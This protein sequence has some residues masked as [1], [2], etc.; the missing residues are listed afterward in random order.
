MILRLSKCIALMLCISPVALIMAQTS[1]PA[2]TD[3]S[4]TSPPTYEPTI[5]TAIT[6]A[7]TTISTIAPTSSAP[8]SVAPITAAPVSLAPTAVNVPITLAPVSAAPTTSAPV[9]LTLAPVSASPTLSPIKAATNSPTTITVTTDAPTKP[10]ATNSPTTIT[11]TT[12]APTTISPVTLAP[13]VATGT[14]TNLS[15][16]ATAAPT[17]SSTTIAPTKSPT[18]PTNAPTLDRIDTSAPTGSPSATPT[19]KAITAA[20]TASPSLTPLI[21]AVSA[22]PTT[23][24]S[25]QTTTQSPSKS[26]TQ[27]PTSSIKPAT[28]SGLKMTLTG[29]GNINDTKSWADN[30]ASFFATQYENSNEMSDIKVDVTYTSEK[31]TSTKKRTMMMRGRRLQTDSVE[32]TYEQLTTYS[33]SNPELTLD[34]VLQMPLMDSTQQAEYVE[35]LKKLNGYASLTTVSTISM[36]SDG[37]N[38]DIVDPGKP[39]TPEKSFPLWAIITIAIVGAALLICIVPFVYRKC[40]R[41]NRSSEQ[42]GLAPPGSSRH[43]NVGEETVGTTDYDYSKAYAASSNFSLS[44][45][46]GTLGERTRQTGDFMPQAGNNTIFSEDPTYNEAA[47]ERS[48]G[49]E[50]MLDVYAPAGKLGVVIDTPNDGAP[51]VHA[52][53]DSSPIADKIQVGDKLVAVDDQDVRTM[54]AIQVSKLISKKSVNASRKM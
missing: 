19:F 3:A 12:D 35:A 18:L 43:Y 26:K 53:K 52:V 9:T 1:S 51:I 38:D 32:V 30:T 34:D 10:S 47:Y 46:G 2:P 16:N 33:T 24:P 8:I 27:P 54:T 13:I 49:R 36:P 11:V 21:P 42:S 44:D 6:E 31:S 5:S 37:G 40:C 15:I 48:S 39:E 14:P 22:P 25:Q 29:I 4:A 17:T 23:S 28:V 20:P 7:P 50:E 41:S 45:A